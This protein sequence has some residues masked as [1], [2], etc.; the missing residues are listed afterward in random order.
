[1]AE[2]CEKAPIEI[3]TN[4]TRGSI[5][6][7]GVD[8]SRYVASFSLNMKA[9]DLPRLTINMLAFDGIKV[10]GDL[11]DVSAIDDE[12]RRFAKLRGD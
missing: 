4:G 1:M 3:R 5:C 12:V 10:D 7:N 11:V 9:G 2:K 8:I 6:V